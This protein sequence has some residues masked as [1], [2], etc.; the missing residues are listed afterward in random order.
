[1]VRGMK[2][3]LEGVVRGP[4][5]DFTPYHAPMS[6]MPRFSEAA[7]DGCCP[8]CGLANVR[9]QAVRNAAR[10]AGKFWLVGPL[11]GPAKKT[12]VCQGCGTRF[13]QG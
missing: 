8:K 5:P 12:I 1:M 10:A 6:A 13:E 11:F 4:C 7:V 9:P 3:A 2:T